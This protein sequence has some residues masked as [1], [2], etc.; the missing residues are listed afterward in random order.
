MTDKANPKKAIT[1]DDIYDPDDLPEL[2]KAHG[3]SPERWV[4]KLAQEM[5]ATKRIPGYDKK[6]R[7]VE[8]IE[9]PVWKIQQEAR[10]DLQAAW[11][12]KAA[13]KMMIGSLEK[14]VREMTEEE[15]R[16]AIRRLDP[17]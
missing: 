3:L 9:E 14:E 10:R 5:E 6:G 17:D 1:V 8:T 4:Q 16:E 13:D 11:G 12:H 15:L 2:L 7:L